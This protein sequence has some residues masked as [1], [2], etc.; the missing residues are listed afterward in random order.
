[1]NPRTLSRRKKTIVP[2]AVAKSMGTL[3]TYAQVAERLGLSIRTVQKLK[4]NGTLPF[5]TPMRGGS[6]RFDPDDVEAM[7]ERNKVDMAPTP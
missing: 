7:I 6:P 2:Y 4:K 5:V 1:M 3:V